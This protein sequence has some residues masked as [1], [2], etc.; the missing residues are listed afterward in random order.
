MEGSGK[1]V[2]VA[3]GINSQAGIIF[4][5]LGAT[6]TEKKRKGKKHKKHGKSAGD[7]ELIDLGNCCFSD[8]VNE[9]ICIDGALQ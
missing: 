3:V 9:F 6:K 8:F 2:V 1:M 4:S 7:N 5:L